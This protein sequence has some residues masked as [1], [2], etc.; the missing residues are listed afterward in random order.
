MYTRVPQEPGRP[1]RLHVQRRNGA[2]GRANPR[3]VGQPS[4][5]GG[6]GVMASTRNGGGNVVRPSE[7]NEVRPEGRWGVGASRSTV[8]AGELS[9][10]EPGGGKGMPDHGV[11]RRK[12]GRCQTPNPVSTTGGQ[13]ADRPVR[14][15]QSD[16]RS[17]NP[18][19][20]MR[21]SCKSG[22]VGSPGG[23]P[24]GLTRPP[25]RGLL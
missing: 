18:K 21:E 7:G 2:T 3:L 4:R 11:V 1:H 15:A 12:H 8:E 22:S 25:M 19:S 6:S 5:P 16:V 23:Q 17:Q 20:R 24:P 9:P 13:T 14:D 10:R